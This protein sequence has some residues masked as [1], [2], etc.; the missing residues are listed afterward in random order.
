[1]ETDCAD[2]IKSSYVNSFLSI[3]PGGS[4]ANHCRVYQQKGALVF[5]KLEISSVKCQ[6]FYIHFS[7]PLHFLHI[8]ETKVL[9]RKRPPGAMSWPDAFI[10]CVMSFPELTIK[11]TCSSSILRWWGVTSSAVISYLK[12][13]SSAPSCQQSP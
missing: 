3:V 12:L 6:Q 2:G 7:L 8:S 10:H 1:M 11:C 5:H 9:Q 4:N 13:N